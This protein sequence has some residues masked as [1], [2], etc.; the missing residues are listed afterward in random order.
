LAEERDCLEVGKEA[1]LSCKGGLEVENEVGS[2]LGE[3]LTI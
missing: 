2:S 1:D 3:G